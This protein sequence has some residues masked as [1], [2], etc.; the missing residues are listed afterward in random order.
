MVPEPAATP[1]TGKILPR[2][3][4]FPLAWRKSKHRQMRLE[5]AG[6]VMATGLETRIGEQFQGV[7]GS[8]EENRRRNLPDTR[9]KERAIRRG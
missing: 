3:W 5:Q 1:A 8:G 7:W 6:E 9:E 2:M 4:I